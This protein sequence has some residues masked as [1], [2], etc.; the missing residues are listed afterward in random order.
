MWHF[1]QKSYNIRQRHLWKLWLLLQMSWLEIGWLDD[2]YSNYRPV[3]TITTILVYP[4]RRYR[5]YFQSCIWKVNRYPIKFESHQR[6]LCP[7]DTVDIW[8]FWSACEN[9]VENNEKNLPTCITMICTS[10]SAQPRSDSKKLNKK[11]THF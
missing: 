10:K 8:Y 4:H 1:I 7:F 2:G 6:N 11:R 5:Y 9:F 3:I